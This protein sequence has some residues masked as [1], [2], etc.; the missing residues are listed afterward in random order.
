MTEN[1]HFEQKRA[2]RAVIL[3][4]APLNQ[5]FSHFFRAKLKQNIAYSLH[6]KRKISL[7]ASIFRQ[8]TIRIRLIAR[9]IQLKPQ[10]YCQKLVTIYV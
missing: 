2:I 5:S 3:H 4:Y 7:D 6:F 1:P 8:M 10:I 9:L